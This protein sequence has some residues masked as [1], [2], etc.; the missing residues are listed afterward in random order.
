LEEQASLNGDPLFWDKK[1]AQRLTSPDGV[2]FLAG[3]EAVGYGGIIKQCAGN[4]NSKKN[5]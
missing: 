4:V 2:D 5:M 3:L 1:R